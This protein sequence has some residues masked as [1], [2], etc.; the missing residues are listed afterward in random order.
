MSANIEAIS[1]VDNYLEQNLYFWKCRTNRGFISSADFMNRN[2]D[3][4]VEV[5]CLSM[6]KNQK[7]SLTT[8]I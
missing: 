3:G 2:L 1:I 8:L 4:R 5:T 6:I 7:N